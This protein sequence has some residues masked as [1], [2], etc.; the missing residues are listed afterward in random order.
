MRM[1]YSAYTAE[2]A[3]YYTEITTPEKLYKDAYCIGL[4]ESPDV[5]SKDTML[6][7]HAFYQML[8]K[9]LFA[10][11][12][13]PAEGYTKTTRYVQVHI[14]RLQEKPPASHPTE[15]ATAAL[16]DM[17]ILSSESISKSEH[18][19]HVEVLEILH[20][21]CGLDPEDEFW[22]RYW[23]KTEAFAPLDAIPE[24]QKIVLMNLY[25]GAKTAI[26]RA[27]EIPN[28][29]FTEYVTE[30]EALVYLTRMVQTGHPH[31][32]LH[33]EQ[34]PMQQPTKRG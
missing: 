30:Y 20:A 8:H 23:Y 9:A 16:T 28:L 5:T 4:I 19:T 7:Q 6:T 2:G 18:I 33:N 34:K 25:S 1:L 21:A 14:K 15:N 32:T 13:H 3:S 10:T 24:Q 26:L 11:H 22:L 27:S 31:S 29:P 17:N 12:S